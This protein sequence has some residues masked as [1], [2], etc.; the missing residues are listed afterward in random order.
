MNRKRKFNNDN[1]KNEIKKI[2]SGIHIPNFLEINNQ[3]QFIKNISEITLLKKLNKDLEVNQKKKIKKMKKIQV[4][5]NELKEE[6]KTLNSKI[7][8]FESEIEY[9]KELL[10][11]LKVENKNEPDLSYI[12]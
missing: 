2:K 8:S 11:E 7:E 5:N 1:F 4:E 6:V 12:N 3:Q 10:T 9:L